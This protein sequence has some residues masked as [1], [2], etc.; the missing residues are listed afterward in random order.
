MNKNLN[1]SQMDLGICMKQPYFESVSSISMNFNI[2][3]H[4]IFEMGL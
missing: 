3:D 4:L 1:K 2:F